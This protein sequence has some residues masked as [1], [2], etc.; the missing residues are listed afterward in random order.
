MWFD[1]KAKLA[2][3]V[4]DTSATSATSATQYP[5]VSQLSRVSQA[6][7]PE[8]QI[9]VEKVVYG[10]TTG[11]FKPEMHGGTCGARGTTWTGRVVSLD[12]WRH[13]TAWDRQGPDGRNWCGI[14]K[15]WKETEGRRK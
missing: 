14:A 1:A 13:L 4:G 5:Q 3:F 6:P 2:E 12:R 15:Q 11:T 9:F 10:A 7:L 8:A